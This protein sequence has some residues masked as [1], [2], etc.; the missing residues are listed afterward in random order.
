MS[1]VEAV[2]ERC[3]NRVTVALERSLCSS[4]GMGM[5]NVAHVGSLRNL[6]TVAHCIRQI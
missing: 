6:L 4:T 2:E 5:D 1:H 3:S